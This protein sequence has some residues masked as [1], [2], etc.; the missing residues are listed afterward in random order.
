[1]LNLKIQIFFLKE[2]RTSNKTSVSMKYRDASVST[3][4][5][6]T[7]PQT[8]NG[9][10]SSTMPEQKSPVQYQIN[11]SPTA[12]TRASTAYGLA[13]SSQTSV[14]TAT[15]NARH[16]HQASSCSPMRTS[17][18]VWTILTVAHLDPTAYQLICLSRLGLSFV[19]WLQYFSTCSLWQALCRSSGLQRTSHQLP[20][21]PTRNPGATSDRSRSLPICARHSNVS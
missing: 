18:P 9:G 13:Q 4:A 20:K 11:R 17:T 21:S 1:M 8:R 7:P 2:R 5:E 10:P 14:N 6:N 16:H 12:S 15:S 3:T 19:G